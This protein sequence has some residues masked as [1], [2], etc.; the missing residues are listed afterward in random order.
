MESTMKLSRRELLILTGGAA[1][2]AAAAS[3]PAVR[4]LLPPRRRVWYQR[5]TTAIPTVCGMCLWNC[6]A[7]QRRP[8]RVR[9]P[10]V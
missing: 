5:P 4:R 10:R 3:A 6:G 1:G 8:G 7:R 2:V 9:D